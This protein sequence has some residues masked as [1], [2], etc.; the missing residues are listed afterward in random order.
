MPET[1]IETTGLIRRRLGEHVFEISLP[2]GK[3]IP[4]HVPKR[5]GDL[6][7]SLSAGA[8]VRL[9]MTPY[10]FEKARIVGLADPPSHA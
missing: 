4:G 6:P 2:N 1:P 9:E 7:S 8:R 3:V 10:D 5:L